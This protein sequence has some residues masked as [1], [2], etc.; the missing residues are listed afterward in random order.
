MKRLFKVIVATSMLALSG[1]APAIM[2][3]D[4]LYGSSGY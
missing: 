2:I 1:N 3:N 4:Q